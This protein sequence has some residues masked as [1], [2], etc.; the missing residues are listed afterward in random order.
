M[1]LAMPAVGLL[2]P[3]SETAEERKQ[4]AQAHFDAIR[5]ANPLVGANSLRIGYHA[6]AL[7]KDNLFGIL[8]F[9]TEDQAREAAEVGESTWYANIRLAEQFS[10]VGEELFIKAKQANL[11]ILADLPESKRLTEYWLRMAAT[12]SIK[13]FQG[14]VDKEMEGKARASDGKEAST[15]LKVSMPVSR[16]NVIEMKLKQAA[17][18]MGEQDTGRAL[19]M[20]LV[21]RT[22]GVSLIGA[23]TQAIEKIAEIKKLGDTGLSVSEVLEKTNAEL[24]AIVE[25]FR[26]ALEAARSHSEKTD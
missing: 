22:E 4:I 7:K 11:K 5:H 15:S 13:V 26:Q 20:I 18:E 8:G 24:D 16:R 17:E 3:T 9:E 2:S 19:E 12:D 10:G 21:E 14:K 6:Y 1:A 25:T 23:I